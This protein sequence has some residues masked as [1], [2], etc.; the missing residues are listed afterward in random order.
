MSNNNFNPVVIMVGTQ[1]SHNIGSA[2]RAMLNFGLTELRLVNPVL[3]GKWYDQ[4]AISL[5]AGADPVLDNA[6]TFSSTKEAIADLN[7]VL[8]TSRRRRDMIKPITNPE[9]GC[10]E[11]VKATVTGS[12]SRILFG[13]EKSGLDNE[14]ISLSDMVVE[15]PVNPDFASLNLSQAVLLLAYE[16][17]MAK[18][19]KLKGDSEDNIILN[20]PN[21]TAPASKKDMEGFF[22]YLTKELDA[23][24]FFEIEERRESTYLKLRNLFF[25]FVI[26]ERELKTMWSI[27]RLLRK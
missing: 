6:K 24:G 27:V 21:N 20:I 10:N 3:G 22:E 11:I 5:A 23:K 2:A 18:N 14:D 15:I 1:L 7:L 8:S 26:T 19:R 25:R 16:W 4:N 13:C 9:Y 17:N 12:K